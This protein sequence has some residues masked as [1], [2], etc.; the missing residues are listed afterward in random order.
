MKKMNI[1]KTLTNVIKGSL[2]AKIIVGVISIIILVSAIAGGYYVYQKSNEWKP[3]ATEEDLANQK[4][5]EI[6]EEQKKKDQKQIRLISLKK[7]LKELDPNF[8]DENS[9]S[10]LND[11]ELD[12]IIEKYENI[13]RKLVNMKVQEELAKKE[14]ENENN[15]KFNENSSSKI[16][17]GESSSS[18]GSSSSSGSSDGISS[19]G[20][21]ISSDKENIVKKNDQE[22][23]PIK[24]SIPS[25]WKEDVASK[26]VASLSGA[27]ANKSGGSDFYNAEQYSAILSQVQGWFNGNGSN[28]GSINSHLNNNVTPKIIGVPLLVTSM[29]NFTVSGLD[30]DTIVN[31]C[32]RNSG[33]A[34]CNHFVFVKINYDSSSDTSTVYYVSGAAM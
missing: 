26:V 9:E 6:T 22:S 24:P 13:K 25:G 33:Y 12:E 28:M 2:K 17:S 11:E 19:S 4:E 10:D 31:S 7:E 20:E 21:D 5:M 3:V 34:A 27:S 14:S 18:E 32:I 8:K 23:T 15:E 29:N 1:I 30:V 16:P